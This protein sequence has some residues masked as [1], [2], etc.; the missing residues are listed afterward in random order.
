MIVNKDNNW[1]KIKEVWSAY[2]FENEMAELEPIAR[3][4][5]AQEI[6]ETDFAEYQKDKVSDGF[7]LFDYLNEKKGVSDEEYIQSILGAINGTIF[8]VVYNNSNE[9]FEIY[10]YV[11]P[12]REKAIEK[13][14]QF[15]DD[16][17]ND[18]DLAES[19]YDYVKTE[20]FN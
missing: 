15:I 6:N 1:V 18:K 19:I 3:K 2:D 9:Y 11:E 7:N 4:V 14:S 17:R 13:I 16:N 12:N 20:V 5:F 10:E 8:S